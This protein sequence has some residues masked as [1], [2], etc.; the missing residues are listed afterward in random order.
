M[1]RSS[2]ASRSSPMIDRWSAAVTR[3][4]WLRTI[5]SFGLPL[6]AMV[7]RIDVLPPWT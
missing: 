7:L 4:Y 6:R 3:R 1:D 5:V 2:L